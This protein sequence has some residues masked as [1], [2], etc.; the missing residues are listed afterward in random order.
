MSAR[1]A[2]SV[3]NEQEI[4]DIEMKIKQKMP[5]KKSYLSLVSDIKM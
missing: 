3:C 5:P 1:Q 2:N 4:Q